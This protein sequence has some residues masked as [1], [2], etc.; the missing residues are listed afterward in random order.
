M[1]EETKSVLKALKKKYEFVE[2]IYEDR[3]KSKHASASLY[4]IRLGVVERVIKDL[5]DLLAGKPLKDYYGTLVELN[6]KSVKPK[7]T[8]VVKRK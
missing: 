3:V 7:T 6:G 8:K 1:N 2:T 4:E 5:N